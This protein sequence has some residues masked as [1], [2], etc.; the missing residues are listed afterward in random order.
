MKAFVSSTFIDLK[1][2]R[3][4][5]IATLRRGGIHVDPMEEW[6]ASSREPRTFSVDRLEGCD[7]CILLVGFRRGFVPKGQTL[8]ITQLEYCAAVERGMDVLPFLAEDDCAWPAEFDERQADPAVGKWRQQLRHDHGV[9]TFQHDDESLDVGPAVLRWVQEN[10]SGQGRSAA[11]RASKFAEPKAASG[12][13]AAPGVGLASRFIRAWR[14]GGW[15]RWSMI[16]VGV[17]VFCMVCAIVAMYQGQ[18]AP[19]VDPQEQLPEFI[20][21]PTFEKGLD[22]WTLER[23]GAG[24]HPFPSGRRTALS[25]YGNAKENNTGRMYQRFRV[26]ANAKE[27][28]FDVHGGNVPGVY[29]ALRQGEK[30]YFRVRGDDSNES[31]HVVWYLHELRGKPVTLEIV[32]DAKGTWGFIGVQGFG[33]IVDDPAPKPAPSKVA[34]EGPFQVGSVWA[35]TNSN[36]QLRVTERTEHRFRAIFRVLGSDEEREINGEINGNNVSWLARDTRVIRGSAGSDNHGTIG[37]DEQGSKI[38]VV[39]R[40]PSSGK[41]L[42][43]TLRLVK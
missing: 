26:P 42:P 32:D 21:N 37:R 2:H 24:F 6:S 17:A 39:R 20:E 9:G 34:I 18:T 38:G 19:V 12:S 28:I 31:K 11:S 33:L 30:T 14:G 4:R 10:S 22:G 16:G 35:T 27:L 7:F 13:K 8:S 5:V 25:T 29:V 41:R 3:A 1:E 36:M 43:Y 40:E 15:A 23:G